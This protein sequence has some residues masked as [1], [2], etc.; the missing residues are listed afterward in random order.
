M[1]SSGELAV[2]LVWQQMPL[3]CVTWLFVMD[4]RRPCSCSEIKIL[5]LFRF[6]IGLETLE[7]LL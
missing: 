5:I 2:I 3:P 6:K 4:H 1:S 7:S